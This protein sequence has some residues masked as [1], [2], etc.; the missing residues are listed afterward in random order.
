MNGDEDLGEDITMKGDKFH[1][2]QNLIQINEPHPVL[3]A[4][5]PQSNGQ[6][7]V[8][9]YVKE[10]I[11]WWVPQ[12]RKLDVP[13]HENGSTGIKT[14][15]APPEQVETLDPKTNLSGRTTFFA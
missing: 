9:T 13:E 4:T 5:K 1:F 7:G 3:D 2:A 10:P 15:L 14:A 11:D 12:S 6:V 8:A